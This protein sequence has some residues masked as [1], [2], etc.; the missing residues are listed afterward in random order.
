MQHYSLVNYG[1]RSEVYSDVNNSIYSK[2]LS[3]GVLNLTT[4]IRIP[5]GKNDVDLSLWAKNALYIQNIY[6]AF[7]CEYPR[8]QQR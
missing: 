6:K 2:I 4:G 5:Y 3:Y 8:S 1:W 7:N